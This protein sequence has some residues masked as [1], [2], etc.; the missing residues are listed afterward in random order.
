MLVKL[1]AIGNK[2]PQNMGLFKMQ[3][4]IS[5]LNLICHACLYK[6]Y[7]R[8]APH[9]YGADSAGKSKLARLLIK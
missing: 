3:E 9:Q 4:I 6:R 5:Y 7:N 1:L 2:K 8:Q